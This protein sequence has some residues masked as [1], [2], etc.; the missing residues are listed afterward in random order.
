MVAV[1]SHLPSR[2]ARYLAL[3]DAAA[4]CGVWLDMIEYDNPGIS[5]AFLAWALARGLDVTRST[6]SDNVVSCGVRIG[7]TGRICVFAVKP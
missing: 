5:E 4:E 3:L 2:T 7:T 1:E 6:L